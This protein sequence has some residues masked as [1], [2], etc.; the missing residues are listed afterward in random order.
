MEKGLV[1]KSTGIWCAVKSE[2]GDIYSCKI[3]G[4][5]R[6]IEIRS[7]NP[8]AVGDW[9]DFKPILSKDEAASQKLGLITSI[10]ERKNYIVRRSQNLSKQAHIIAANI[11]LAFLVSTINYPITSTTFMDRFLASAE[12]YSIPVVIIFNKS[13]LYNKE[14]TEYMNYLVSVYNQIGYRCLETSAKNNKGI[15]ELK[16]LMHNKI[17]VFSGHSGV[18][19]STLINIIDPRLKLKTEEISD[20]HQK[21]KHTTSFSEL[22]EL[23][24]GGYIIDTPGIKGF[25]MLDMEP[26]E[27]SHYFPEIFKI[28]AKCLYQNC[29]H[30]HEPDCAIKAAVNQGI[31]AETRY[32]SY[33]GLLEGDDK[34]RKAPE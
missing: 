22:F 3:K 1:I 20:Y 19:K 23:Y 25:G 4:N 34:Y 13:D 30:T 6:L 5:F 9:V 12:A 16:I 10:H 14:E 24:F 21:G 33:L 27:I 26:W 29:S 15:E 7:T 2:K 11:D 8:L 17:S 31:I 32:V 28:S 18:G